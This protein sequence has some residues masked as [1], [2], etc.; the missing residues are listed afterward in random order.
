MS[1]HL[2]YPLRLRPH[3]M[4]PLA[5]EYL[6]PNP[7]PIYDLR[8]GKILGTH[9]GLWTRTIGQGAGIPGS[10]ERRYVASKNKAENAIYVVN[11]S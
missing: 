3:A 5:E 7:G 8:T 10:K 9:N 4:Y 11:G 6:E 1:V 2:L